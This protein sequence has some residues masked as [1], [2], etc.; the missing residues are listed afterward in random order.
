MG[1]GDRVSVFDRERL[2]ARSLARIRVV[3]HTQR[4]RQA[5]YASSQRSLPG[6]DTFGLF[7]RGAVES[8]L[9]VELFG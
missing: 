5:M 4:H 2:N 3:L 1:G 6:V 7:L 9:V 8:K